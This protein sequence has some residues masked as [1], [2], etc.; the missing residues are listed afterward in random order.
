M[1]RQS[2]LF[3]DSN[4]QPV[5]QRLQ[6]LYTVYNYRD[7]EDRAALLAEAAKSVR[8]IFTNESSWVPSLMDAL[9]LVELIVVTSNGYERIDL[10]KRV[11][12]IYRNVNHAAA[13]VP[14]TPHPRA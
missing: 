11:S 9:P 3:V 12:L 6:T 10:A 13:E 14:F 8:A 1:I 4:D 7:A 2:V 5:L